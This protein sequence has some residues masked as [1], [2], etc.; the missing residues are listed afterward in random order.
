MVDALEGGIKGLEVALQ[1]R[2]GID[3]ERSAVFVNQ[4]GHGNVLGVQL[5]VLVLKMV[6]MRSPFGIRGRMGSE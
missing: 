4:I 5:T 3:V 6:H 2:G 1:G